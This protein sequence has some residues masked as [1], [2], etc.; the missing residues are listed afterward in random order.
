MNLEEGRE[1]DGAPST[2]QHKPG[3]GSRDPRAES[4]G[5]N[6]ATAPLGGPPGGEQWVGGC[7]EEVGE[8]VVDC[9]IR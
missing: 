9:R 4:V 3:A 1:G 6:A 7:G 2:I 5:P 8:A